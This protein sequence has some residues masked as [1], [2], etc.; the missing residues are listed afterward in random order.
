MNRFMTFEG[1]QPIWLDDLDFIQD[2]L[3]EE[4]RKI[5]EGLVG[6]ADEIVI[7][8]GC[9]PKPQSDGTIRYTKGVIYYRGELLSVPEAD[10][11]DTNAR[12]RIEETYDQSGD[13]TMQDSSEEVSCYRIRTGHLVGPRNLSD[14]PDTLPAVADCKRLDDILKERIGE[15]VVCTGVYTND[16]YSRAF[17]H[18]TRR[19]DT[20]LLTCQM[21]GKD[22][23]F[24]IVI[25]DSDFRENICYNPSTAGTQNP[26]GEQWYIG[27]NFI[28]FMCR[29]KE[30]HSK[31][32]MATVSTVIEN[33]ECHLK[34]LA[35]CRDMSLANEFM[36]GFTT[37]LVN[38]KYIYHESDTNRQ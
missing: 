35:P 24:D 25:D 33:N 9:E 13:R 7:L 16:N 14:R 6:D 23:L 18:L 19:D 38:R 11:V 15:K 5:V 10:L 27:K 21:W 28:S 31:T 12:I 26:N 30:G 2:T 20:Y 1:R 32:G 4:I 22:L 17:V 34:I 3:A 8:S 36:G 37:I 29:D